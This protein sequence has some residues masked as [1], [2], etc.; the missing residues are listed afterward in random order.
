MARGKQGPGKG[1]EQRERGEV[2]AAP[3]LARVYE[4]PDLLGKLL[5]KAIQLP[6]GLEAGQ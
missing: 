5:E 4:G 1:G 3:S 6:S 2:A